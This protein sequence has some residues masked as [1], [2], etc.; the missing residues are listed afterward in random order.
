MTVVMQVCVQI[1]ML[2]QERTC[3]A[4][5]GKYSGHSFLDIYKCACIVTTL[6][7]LRRRELMFNVH[8]E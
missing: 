1:D 8:R 5:L 6:Y 3:C 4:F 2:L 7:F